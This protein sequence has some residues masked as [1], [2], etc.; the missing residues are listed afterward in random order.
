MFTI[1]LISQELTGGEKGR[2]ERSFAQ[3]WEAGL[4]CAGADVQGPALAL[5]R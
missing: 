5:G 1:K 2:T 4:W 3:L